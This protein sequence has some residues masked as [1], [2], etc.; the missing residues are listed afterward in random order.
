MFLVIPLHRE[1]LRQMMQR[2]LVTHSIKIEVLKMLKKQIVD[3]RLAHGDIKDFLVF[4]KPQFWVWFEKPSSSPKTCWSTMTKAVGLFPNSDAYSPI[5][6]HLALSILAEH[7]CTPDQIR[8]ILRKK[9]FSHLVDWP[10]NSSKQETVK[11]YEK[12]EIQIFYWLRIKNGY[13]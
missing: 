1:S 13:T 5:G 3:N 2:G 10:W 9:T 6:A 8:I 11:I 4:E 12:F 7:R